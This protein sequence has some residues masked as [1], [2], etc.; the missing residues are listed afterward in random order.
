MRS[1]NCAICS[2]E[3]GLSDNLYAFRVADHTWFKCPNGHKNRFAGPNPSERKIAALER[4]LE[5]HRELN[6]KNQAELEEW[7]TALRHCPICKQ[8]VSGARSGE[9]AAHKLSVHLQQIHAARGAV[10]ALMP[11][12]PA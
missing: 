10:L 6:A 4:L 5:R 8:R 9:V 7:K 12:S 1:M 11:G 2:V 3:F